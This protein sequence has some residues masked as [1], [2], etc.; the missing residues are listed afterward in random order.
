MRV[1]TIILGAALALTVLPAAP[2]AAA[3]GTLE[4]YRNAATVR[5]RLNGLT[6]GV[7]DA[8]NWIDGTSRFWYRLSVAGGHE[9]VLVDAETQQKTPAFDH[10]ALAEGLSAATGAE[11]TA[12]TLP[13][14]SFTYVQDGEA[15]EVGAAGDEWRCSLADFACE[16]IEEEAGGGGRGGGGGGFGSFP[17]D[18]N[19]GPPRVSPDGLTEAFIHN[20]NV[21]IRPVAGQADAGQGGGAGRGDPSHTMLSYDGSEG[22]SYQLQSIRWSPDSKKLVAYRQR[23]GYHRTVYFVLSSP[24]DQL[25]PKLDSMFYRKPGDVLDLNR[26][27]LFDVESASATQI[28]DDL[29]PNAYRISSVEWRA[30]GR[31]FTFE[32][33][34]RGHQV[35]RVIEVDAET[36]AARA[37]ISE[38]VPTFFNYRRMR[39]NTRDSGKQFRYDID[40][41]REVIWMSER[42]GWNHLYLYDGVTGEVKNRITKGEWV[43]RAVD[44]VDVAGRRIWFEA[45]GMIPGQDPYFIHHYRIDFDGS[46]LV[47]YTEADGNHAIYWSPDRRFYVDRYSRVDMPTVLELR[48]GSDQRLL[49]ELEKGDMSA[50]FATGWQ[51]PE[52]FVA[53]GRD[54]VTDI[55]GII[56]RP[57]NFDPTRRYAVIEN[58]Y[59]GPHGSHVPKDWSPVSNMQSMAELGFVVVQIDGMGTSNRSKAFHDVAWQNLGDAGFP[60]RILWHR[61]VAERYAWYDIS[62]VGITGGSAG[63][64]NSTG[65]LLF[66]GDF[67]KVAVSS[68]GCHDNRMDKIWWNEHWMGWPLGPHYEASSNMVNAHRLTG[69]LLLAVGEHDRNV[70]PS[71]TMQLVKALIDADRQ[72]D[73]YVQPGGGHGVGGQFRQRRDDYFVKLLKSR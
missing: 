52:V 12:V 10:A 19:S 54:G 67:Y 45:S 15:I 56:V 48:R 36:G 50:Q 44:S 72:F 9:F 53:K 5:Q 33:N 51:P 40:D 39:T 59:A 71:S 69:R 7:P 73:L 23:P 6:V 14:R 68:A 29:F 2:P 16:A 42:D 26:P 57:T 62:R 11:Y 28:D 66:H 3:Q 20:Y 35:Y 21:A 25:Q 63:G 61:A 58:I 37:V 60:D 13:F 38:E 18:R 1:H 49:A 65:A 55:W 27:V 17:I 30:D 46:N 32:Y 4:D 47:Q 31:A 24:E 34:Q 22:D 43:V 8:P 64:Q 41:G 70:D